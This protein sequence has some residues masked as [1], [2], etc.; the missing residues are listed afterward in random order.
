[1]AT[2]LKPNGTARSAE[3]LGGDPDFFTVMTLVDITDTGV[4]DSRLSPAKAYNQAQNLNSLIQCVSLRVQP[5]LIST[6]IL[7]AEAMAD[8]EFGSAHTGNK[9]VWVLKF[10]TERSGYTDENKLKAD[11]DG[12]PII[13]GLD[14]TAS[15][16]TAVFNGL[17]AVNKNIYFVQHTTL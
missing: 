16:V 12:L 4:S 5:N 7:L 14:E 11:V 1:M 8:H 2:I 10:A 3:N 9:T 17:S 15:F 6:D 13:T